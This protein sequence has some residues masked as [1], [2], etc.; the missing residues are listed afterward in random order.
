M[1]AADTQTFAQPDFSEWSEEM[2]AEYR[3]DRCNADCTPSF[4]S[5]ATV[6]DIFQ[7]ARATQTHLATSFLFAVYVRACAELAGEGRRPT[8]DRANRASSSPLGPSRIRAGFEGQIRIDW[9]HRDDDAGIA[10]ADRDG[11]Y[12]SPEERQGAAPDDRS[13]LYSMTLCIAELFV[14]KRL[15]DR[16]SI[17][18]SEGW[19][20]FAELMEKGTRLRRDLGLLFLKA[21]DPNFE[22]RTPG[23][24]AMVEELVRIGRKNGLK[25]P[26]SAIASHLHRLFGDPPEVDPVAPRTKSRRAWGSLDVFASLRTPAPLRARQL[27][28]PPSPTAHRLFASSNRVAPPP[29]PLPSFELPTEQPSLSSLLPSSPPRS[30]DTPPPVA[31]SVPPVPSPAGVLSDRLGW[32]NIAIARLSPATKSVVVG[33]VIAALLA[34]PFLKSRTSKVVTVA[35]GPGGEL[36][37]DVQVVLDGKQSCAGARC[38]FEASPGVHEVTAHAEGYI[39]QI[40]LVAIP[41]GETAAINFR[42]ERGGSSLDVSGHPEGASLVIDGRWIGRLPLRVDLAPGLHRVRIEA[43][44]F[45]PDERIVDLKVA[46]A[47]RIADIALLPRRTA[48]VDELAGESA[49][50]GAGSLRHW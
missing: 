18:D 29:T 6:E 32:S 41:S 42:L 44:R 22:H 27:L 8:F 38:A 28:P 17:V 24:N 13:D 50:T 43:D 47:R 36:L 11:C 12:R 23:P 20:D 14:L 21:L 40:Q 15:S 1:A 49:L 3:R 35:A 39:S 25:A 16:N 7:R 45:F 26:R 33:A 9:T 30:T 48:P 4:P 19:A 46:E 10:G 34:P 31:R 2:T 5:E 37:P